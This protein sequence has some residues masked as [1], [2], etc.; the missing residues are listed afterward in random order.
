MLKMLWG[1]WGLGRRVKAMTA[2]NEEIIARLV[3]IDTQLRSLQ[4]SIAQV[5]TKEKSIMVSVADIQAKADATLANVRAETDVVNAVKQVVQ[6]NN[7]MIA[8]LKQQLADAIANGADA[9]QLQTL[10]D[11][12]DAIQAANTSNTQVVADAVAAGTPAA[13][14]P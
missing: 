13:P 12:L 8:A 10:S 5:L 3:V 6:L 2:A 7:D 9:A 1:Y 4:A 11:T 14:T